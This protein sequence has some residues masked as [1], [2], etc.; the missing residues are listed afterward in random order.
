MV[1]ENLTDIPTEIILE[2]GRIALWMQTL[3][4]IV[5]LWIVFNI[6]T[7]IVNRKKRK[8]IDKIQ[9]DLKRIETKI[10]KLLK[11]K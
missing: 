3:G 2:I 7:L 11:K 6:I 1:I 4:I 10:D 8:A 5:L 9:K